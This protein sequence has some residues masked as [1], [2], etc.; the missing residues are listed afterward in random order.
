M[1]SPLSRRPPVR[2]SADFSKGD[3]CRIARLCRFYGCLPHAL[4]KLTPLELALAEDAH[5]AWL[6][7]LPAEGMMGVLDVGSVV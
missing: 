4:L 6:S 3:L 1:P 5:A 7:E 2:R